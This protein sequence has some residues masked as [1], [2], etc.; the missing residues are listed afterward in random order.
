MASEE[1]PLTNEPPAHAPIA[2]RHAV[3]GNRR[4]PIPRLSGHEQ[5]YWE[6]ATF[7]TD[8]LAG[9]ARVQK[10]LPPKYFYDETGSALFDRI[11]ELPEYYPTRAESRILEAHA[12]AIGELLGPGAL[13][14]ELGSGSSLKTERLLRALPEP[15]AY[16]PVDLSR[17]HL[18]KAV[19]R[20]REREPGLV[21]VP[22]HADFTQNFTLPP[23][24]ARARHVTVFFPGSTIGN[25]EPHDA[26]LLMRKIH[27]RVAPDGFF[28]VGVDN[29][30]DPAVLERAYN[31]S[32][33]VTAAFNRNILERVRR[34]LDSDVD[35]DGFSHVA[36]YNVPA[37]RIEMHLRSTAAH[38]VHVEGRR[39]D[40]RAGETIHTENS[41]KYAVA[42]FQA[43]ALRAGFRPQ[44]VWQDDEGL[45]SL[46]CLRP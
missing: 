28:L 39:F 32:Q 7:R 45:F 10:T 44:E 29:K 19:A 42:E 9:L 34:E 13:L 3:I 37:G 25:L 20:L 24:A 33:G 27:R 17:A 1:S 6:T 21:V 40:F 31:D 30:K 14:V 43:L 8:V 35:P 12:P 23:A 5:P 41:Y 4:S 26:V 16:V 2:D 36:A 18:L 38:A 11:C 46:H 22:V 15:A